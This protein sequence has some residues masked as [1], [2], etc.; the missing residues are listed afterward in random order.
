M[1][2]LLLVRHGQSEWNAVGRWQ[3]KADP[4]LTEFGR[5]QALHAAQRIGS[6][7]VIVSSPLVRALETAQII[8][9]QIGV[10]PIVVDADLMERDAGEW[11]G[12]TRAEIEEQWP[13]YLSLGKWPP[14]Y[15]VHDQLLLRTRAALDRIHAEYEGA[16]VLVLT[17]GGVIGT[18]E[19]QHLE[20]WQRMPNLGGRVFIHHGDHL[21]LGDRV[22]LVDDDEI[23]VPDQI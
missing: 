14:G 1:T 9:A 12:L 20:Q 10:G 6:V 18:L 7:D 22:V 2:R 11:E 4:A 19:V 17:H 16:D 8:S 15:E 23:T 5:L 3:G 13:R 21:E